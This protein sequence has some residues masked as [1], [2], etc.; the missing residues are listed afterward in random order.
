MLLRGAPGFWRVKA[1]ATCKSVCVFSKCYTISFFEWTHFGRKKRN[2]PV[3]FSGQKRLFVKRVGMSE[4][5]QKSKGD[6]E[7]FSASCQKAAADKRSG[8]A[9]QMMEKQLERREAERGDTL[10]VEAP[11]CQ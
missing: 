1:C 7:I 9:V 5:G 3:A 11:L 8:T 2:I 10:Q 4:K 6:D